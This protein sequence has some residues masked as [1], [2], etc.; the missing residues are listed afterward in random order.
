MSKE[1]KTKEPTIAEMVELVTTLRAERDSLAGTLE[2]YKGKVG[3]LEANEARLNKI[4]ANSVLTNK[5]T[6]NSNL[7]EKSFGEFYVEAIREMKN[8]D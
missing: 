4:V 8:N 1:E 3:E 7:N 5:P 2:E 6:E